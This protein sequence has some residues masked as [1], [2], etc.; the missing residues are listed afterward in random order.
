MVWPGLSLRDG[1]ATISLGV[2]IGLVMITLLA[3]LLRK[4]GLF[5]RVPPDLLDG[6]AAVMVT[7]Y[8][9]YFLRLAC[10]AVA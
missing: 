7:A 6:I 8:G 10:L 5:R 3:L 1:A 9:L 4:T 2:G